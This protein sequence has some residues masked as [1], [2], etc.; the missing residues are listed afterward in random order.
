MESVLSTFL[1]VVIAICIC[2]I[3]LCLIRTIKGPTITDRLVA[4]N[5]I[6]T[7]VIIIIAALTVKLGEAWLAD[8]AAVYAIISFIAIVVFTKI[9]IGEYRVKHADELR[10]DAEAVENESAKKSMKNSKAEKFEVTGSI[11]IPK[12]RQGKRKPELKK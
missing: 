9:Y 4:V 1:T 3:F 12:T 8:V 11:N 10:A 2:L 6:G 7:Q 5:M